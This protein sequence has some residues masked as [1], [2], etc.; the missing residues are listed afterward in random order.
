L[1]DAEAKDVLS[2]IETSLNNQIPE[3]VSKTT[4]LHNAIPVKPEIDYSATTD[5]PIDSEIQPY[6]EFW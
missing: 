4:Q 6:D 3:K 5:R 2:I 1:R